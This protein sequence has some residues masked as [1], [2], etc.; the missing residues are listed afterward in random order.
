LTTPASA[1]ASRP[2]PATE[3]VND[4]V[5][6]VGTV[7]GSGSQTA[8]MVILRAVF[9]MGVP[10]SGK[11]VFP[12]NIQGLPTW[13][14]IRVSGAGYT[15]R[16]PRFDLVVLRSP[17]LGDA[18][19]AAALVEP[20]GCLYWEIERG[21]RRK[22]D[23]GSRLTFGSRERRSP[24]RL[25]RLRTHLD[26]L[27][28]TCIGFHWHRPSFREALEIVPLEH[29]GTLQYVLSGAADRFSGRAKRA[30][31]RL[32]HRAGLLQDLVSCVSVVA[33]KSGY[34]QEET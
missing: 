13:Y 8:N 21:G 12:S 20:G 15:A 4:F 22:W 27:G 24:G 31:G 14:E 5:I 18:S 33:C 6:R 19:R 16:T 9:Q 29:D 30:L 23:W 2:A 1:A 11:N 10:C 32:L 28:F 3:C 34:V 7:N 17:R 26:R 25:V